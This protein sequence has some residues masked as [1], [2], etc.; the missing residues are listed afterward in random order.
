M[1]APPSRP[2]RPLVVAHRGDPWGCT[3]NTLD[4]VASA[5]TLGADAV[6]VD[7][8]C[9]LDGVPVLHHDA[10]LA[11]VHGR[12]E[13]LALLPAERLTRL[14]PGVPLLADVLD[15]L[16]ATTTPLLLDLRSLRAAHAALGVVTGSRHARHTGLL[17]TGGVWFCGRPHVLARIRQVVPH[18]RILLSWRRPTAPPEALV[19]AVRPDWF[20]PWHRLVDEA[21]VAAWHRRGV[22]VSAWTVD[23][24]PRRAQLAAWG[25]EAFITNDVRGALAD[26]DRAATGA[27]PA[28]ALRR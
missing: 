2:S 24:A 28:V 19:R 10:T 22:P 27:P 4:A 14:A 17:A 18:A 26:R 13:R 1:S 3:E 15:L 25:V 12:R 20:N 5:V 11:R 16:R 9:T 21:V 8:R 7:V 6:E 23:D